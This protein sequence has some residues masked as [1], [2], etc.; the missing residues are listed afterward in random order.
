MQC[1]IMLR[2]LIDIICARCLDLSQSPAFLGYHD[3]LK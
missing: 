3:I 2:E 1:D